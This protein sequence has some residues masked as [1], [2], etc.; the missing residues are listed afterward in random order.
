[1]KKQKYN[2][3]FRIP[4]ILYK[5]ILED[6]KRPHPF[7][8]ERVGFLYTRSKVLIENNYLI[9]AFDYS[10]VEDDDYIEDKTVSARIGSVA[11]RKAMQSIFDYGCGCFHIHLHKHKG[12]P[13]PS[14]TDKGLTEVANSLSNIA[15]KEANGVLILSE[16]DFY[17]EIKIGNEK[18]FF[19]AVSYTVVGYPLTL[20]FLNKSTSK[21]NVYDR[22]SFLGNNSQF[23]F[24]NIRIGI[25]GYG[26][27]GSH[28]GQQLAHIG[29][30][31]IIIFDF[32]RVEETN[33]NRMIGAWF[34]DIK[35]SLLKTDVAKRVIE[36]IN[37]QARVTLINNKWQKSSEALQCCDVVFGCI[38]SY[39][40]RLQLESECR[41]FLIPFIDIGMDVHEEKGYSMSGQI[42]LS[43]P[44]MVCMSCYGFLTE[45]KLA[46]EAEKYGKVGGRPQ[47]VW[48]NGVL[49]ST[50]VGVC[51][52]LVT[53]WT[54]E[55]DKLIY[56]SYD[57]NSGI[58][59]DHI[60]KKH[61]CKS[62]S[63]F[64]LKEIGSVFYRK[65]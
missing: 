11:I 3:Q 65:L 43:M 58:L 44:G 42:I 2:I 36:K 35:K 14:F 21:R 52:D 20:K 13:S 63:H 28:I 19:H 26:G 61:V 7:A 10:S 59:S 45:E 27:G 18:D 50:A 4:Q 31:N 46:K 12:K 47:V 25:V 60:R 1:M 55:K 32:D 38:D 15:S 5:T 8:Y 24:E 17:S 37:L 30:K 62:C 6:L 56:L 39:T 33:L 22:Q 54:K 64:S 16:D 34:T 48:P 40:E 23:L 51:I 53:G 41:R 49:A 29:V 9:I 57:G